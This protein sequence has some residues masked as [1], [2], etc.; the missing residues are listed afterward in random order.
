[1]FKK[2]YVEITNNCN[3]NCDFCIKNQ[4]KSQFI[5]LDN[6]KRLLNKIDKYTDYLYFHVMGEPL[7]HPKINELI[8]MASD[9][10]KINI[11]T[12]GF[13]IK[14]IENNSN[15]RQINV[16]LHSFN[17]KYNISYENYI[18]D[19]FEV[20]DKLLEKNTIINYRLWVGSL[21]KNKIIND[22]E[23]KYNI[24]I[25]NN[26]NIK[27]CN[28]VYYSVDEEFIW[29]SYNNNYYNETGGC[30][31]TIDHIGILVDGTVVPC[32]LDSGGVINL[33]NIYTDTMDDVLNS[34]SF[35]KIKEGFKN[36]IK[37]H[38]LCKKCNFYN[39]KIGCE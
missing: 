4:R 32:C 31:G 34:D 29:P 37:V 30:R 23:K 20:T 12:N 3:L 8:N 22:L 27:L 11:T 36:N 15:I 7:L 28:N 2:I 35:I 1:M 13:L 39:V 18:N 26:K 17:D 10:F 16:S 24:K 33:G 19:I 14:R 38:P 9:K 25:S 5:S 21:Y 6:F